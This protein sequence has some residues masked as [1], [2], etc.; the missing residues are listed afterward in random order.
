MTILSQPKRWLTINEACAYCGL[1]RPTLSRWLS[2]GRLRPH[3]PC[4]SG[5]PVLIDRTELDK[6]IEASAV[7]A[8]DDPLRPA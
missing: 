8:E 2:S 4:G 6:L 3:D 1:S 5:R 7:H